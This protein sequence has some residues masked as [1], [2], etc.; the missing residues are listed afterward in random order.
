MYVTNCYIVYKKIYFI[1]AKNGMLVNMY[2]NIQMY[3]YVY[4][5]VVNI[6]INTYITN[7]YICSFHIMIMLLSLKFVEIVLLVVV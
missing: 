4:N 5:V 1:I 2:E 3:V 6:C 7:T